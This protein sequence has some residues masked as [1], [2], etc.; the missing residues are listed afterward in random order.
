MVAGVENVLKVLESVAFRRLPKPLLVAG[1]TFDF[2]A[3]VTGIG[4][5]N[6]LVVVSAQEIDSRRLVRL[7]SGLSR[8]LDRSGSRRPVS[9]VLLGTPSDQSVIAE[10]ENHARVMVIDCGEPTEEVIR[11]SIAVL[12]PL[13]LPGAQKVSVDPLE[14]LVT[15]L[16]SEMTPEHGSL[17]DAARIGTDAV[18]EAFRDYIDDAVPGSSEEVDR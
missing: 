10:L 4:V 7:L 16:A 14:E 9:L 1:T 11:A 8:S 17:I 3:A 12:L 15:S 13:D 6:D 5:S 18:R 2:D